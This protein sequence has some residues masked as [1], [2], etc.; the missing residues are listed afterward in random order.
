MT[1]LVWRG[2]DVNG[3]RQRLSSLQKHKDDTWIV[4]SIFFSWKID[5]MCID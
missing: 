1:E 4:S 5:W 2:K 3:T